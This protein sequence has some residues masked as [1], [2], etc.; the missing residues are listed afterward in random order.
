M[1]RAPARWTAVPW[2]CRPRSLTD[3][4]ARGRR[5]RGRR[6][7]RRHRHVPAAHPDLVLR[8]SATPAGPPSA[9]A[10]RWSSPPGT[11]CGIDPTPDVGDEHRT[12][13]EQVGGQVDRHAVGGGAARPE[14]R[15]CP[16]VDGD[17]ATAWRVG[18]ED[19]SGTHCACA[20]RGR[21]R[22]DH[23]ILA[24]P[25]DG[26]RDRSSP[27][28]DSASTIEP[29]DR[30]GPHRQSFT[31]RR[32]GRR[33]G[34]FAESEVLE[35]EISRSCPRPPFDPALANAVGFAEI[36]LAERGGRGV[37][38]GAH[39]PPGSGL[40]CRPSHRHRAHPPPVRTRATR[41]RQDQEPRA[42]PPVRAA[43][44]ARRS[45][46]PAPLGSTRTHRRRDLD[47]LLGTD[48]GVGPSWRPRRT[49]AA[50]WARGRL[51]CSTAIPRRCGRAPSAAGRPG[52][53]PSPAA[54]GPVTGPGGARRATDDRH[55][56]P[57]TLTLEADGRW[58]VGR[59]S[60]RPP[61]AAR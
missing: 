28:F 1:R 55:S 50:T 44:G 41:G 58:W 21:H 9:P 42:A 45:R 43:R 12:V 61:T 20:P 30:R 6:R 57:G 37:G 33:L 53:P 18:G 52:T 16:A 15:A 46:S 60:P 31:R 23:L 24:Q 40:G 36:T 26:P 22:R 17:V 51:G 48:L 3:D 8:R 10:R 56:V 29:A 4:A 34:R 49:S 32:S 59:P 35:V 19:P 5:C 39:R 47:R 14:D 2:C 38:A 25:T 11:T 27:T 54:A 7:P 13:V